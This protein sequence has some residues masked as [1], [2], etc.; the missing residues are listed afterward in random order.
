MGIAS[1]RGASPETATAGCPRLPWCGVSVQAAERRTQSAEEGF[2][3]DR[4]QMHHWWMEK[5]CADTR[6]WA[7]RPM[8]VWG[9]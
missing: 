1:P 4:G 9:W 2:T 6:V 7:G 8:G 5:A 3:T